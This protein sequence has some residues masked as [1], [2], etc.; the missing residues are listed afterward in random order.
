MKQFKTESKRVLDLM[1]NSIYTNKEIFLREL[2][3]N[4]S[5]ATDK[6]KF[7]SLTDSK[8]VSDFN[9]TIT[10]NKADNTLTVEDNGIG[11]T[12]ADLEKNLGTIAE[13]GTLAFKKDNEGKTDAELIG[14]FGVGF[15]SA[16]MVADKI[17]VY[18]KAYNSDEAYKWTSKGVEGYEISKTDKDSVGTKIILTLK[19]DTDDEKYSDYLEEY[20][21]RALVKQYSDY[22]RYPIRMLATRSKKK[23]GSPDDKPEYETY[24]EWET[25]NGMVPI[26]K[27]PKSEV[28]K[29]N[30]D[31]FYKSEFHDYEAP[32]K[33]VYAKIE[34]AVTYDTL[35]YIPSRAPYDYYSKDYK[36]GLKLYSNGVMIMEKCE[37]LLP[38]YFGFVRGIVDS[39]DLNLNISR[40]I[41]QQD[42]QVKAI[43]TSL[44]K[45]IS[46]E[47]KKLLETERE[48]YEKAFTEFGLSI[49]FGVYAGFG[50]KKDALKDFLMFY[51]SKK[52]KLVTL[53][54]YVKEMQE[55][56]D[57]IYYACGESYE[58]IARL[59]QI[60]KAKDK[61][62][63]ILFFKDG[64]DEFVAKILNDYDGKKFKSVSEA[65]FTLDSETEKKELDEKKE[66]LKEVIALVK[67]S[68][69]D[70]VKEVKL[71]SNLKTYPVCLTADGEISIEMEKV[72]NSMPNADGKVKA[73]K[74]LELNADHKIIE[75]LKTL[76]ETDKNALKNY[77]VVLYEEARL[78]EGLSVDDV[79]GFVLAISDII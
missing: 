13:S 29:E 25:L 16:F 62:Y 8:V 30:L 68:L 54:E 24:S 21:I 56:Q 37:D 11:M 31:E 79:S 45:K 36:K 64:V 43:A 72:L 75:K 22:I 46:A 53:A 50:Y 6:L 47:L 51:S 67:E 39:S 1:I 14:Q 57:A 49:K 44:E 27:K 69:G 12:E 42:R 52:E 32:I 63:E 65:D 23:E 33:G 15:Y 40:E 76:Y 7:I 4:A 18:T 74:I 59:P 61:G 28:T 70:K 55:G 78:L 20:K 58:K 34:G 77:A 10:P 41:L 38:D 9:I 5:D 17:E 71:S 3:S 35:L 73:E 60:E 2:I 19:K 48:A 66:S 26:W